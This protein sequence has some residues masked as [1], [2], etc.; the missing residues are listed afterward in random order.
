[1]TQTLD[2]RMPYMDAKWSEKVASVVAPPT[3]V[4]LPSRLLKPSQSS[5]STEPELFGIGTPKL[6]HVGKVNLPTAVDDFCLDRDQ[7]DEESYHAPRA[8]GIGRL[9]LPIGEFE[10]VA[11]ATAPSCPPLQHE[12]TSR[13]DGESESESESELDGGQDHGEELPGRSPHPSCQSSSSSMSRA[14]PAQVVDQQTRLPHHLLVRGSCLCD[15]LYRWT[16]ILPASVNDGRPIYWNEAMDRYLY[17][18]LPSSAWLMGQHYTERNR[19]AYGRGEGWPSEVKEWYQWE[20][21]AKAWTTP[22]IFVVEI[23]AAIGQ[24]AL[25]ESLSAPGPTELA[26]EGLSGDRPLNDDDGFQK[27][28]SLDD[29]LATR[30]LELA[31]SVCVP[32]D[33]F[34]LLSPRVD[35]VLGSDP[36]TAVSI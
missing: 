34:D 16:D 11:Q 23:A 14:P 28:E 27:A 1:M 19:R 31:R 5:R 33:S 18:W 21:E 8:T 15:G 17:Y 9:R 24:G 36:M 32:C 3:E 25:N 35:L 20:P 10:L 29:V 12:A 13:S 30:K 22:G 26:P 7:D 2:A 6:S 4:P